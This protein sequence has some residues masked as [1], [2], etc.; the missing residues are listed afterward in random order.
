MDETDRIHA[1][2]AR[3][4]ALGAPGAPA[5]DAKLS[6][7]ADVE[8]GAEQRTLKASRTPSTNDGHEKDEVA[9]EKKGLKG[10][11][12]SRLTHQAALVAVVVSTSQY[13][14]PFA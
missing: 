8:D 5:T 11:A 12:H 10:V 13:A 14:R 4:E 7:A 9:D 1:V 2:P 3:D 6:H